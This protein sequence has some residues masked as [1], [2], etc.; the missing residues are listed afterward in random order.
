MKKSL[1]ALAAL[2]AVTAANALTVTNS[3]DGSVLA[4][5]VLGASSS[6]MI[7]GGS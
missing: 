7:V 1:L 4:N 6:L 2:C 3:N 5:A